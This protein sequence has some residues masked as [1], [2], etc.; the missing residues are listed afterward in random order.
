MTRMA[1]SLTHCAN[2]WITSSTICRPPVLL[3]SRERPMLL[4]PLDDDIEVLSQQVTPANQIHRRT[5][6]SLQVVVDASISLFE[7]QAR[8][9]SGLSCRPGR[10]EGNV[11]PQELVDL[12][13]ISHRW[14]PE[15]PAGGRRQWHRNFRVTDT[16]KVVSISIH[17]WHEI[18]APL[19]RRTG[20]YRPWLIRDW[21]SRQTSE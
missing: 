7:G 5:S 12:T 18:L 13:R 3:P 10:R 21:G 4:C 6:N 19:A 11:R 15:V 20:R 17:L 8:I 14:I 2:S 1:F 9:P 16:A